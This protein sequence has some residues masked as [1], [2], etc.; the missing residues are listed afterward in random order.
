VDGWHAWAVQLRFSAKEG[1]NWARALAR[2]K[3]GSDGYQTKAHA[4]AARQT[5][6]RA[7]CTYSFSSGYWKSIPRVNSAAQPFTP[8]DVSSN[9]HE[10]GPRSGGSGIQEI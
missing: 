5:G 8:L 4:P 3:Q 7:F 6:K 1:A 10:T 9:T 2:R